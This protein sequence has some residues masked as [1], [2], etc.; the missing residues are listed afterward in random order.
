MGAT[1]MCC[2]LGN[3]GVPPF[4]YVDIEEFEGTW[5]GVEV[6]REF[7]MPNS[8]NYPSNKRGFETYV[9]D[10]THYYMAKALQSREWKDLIRN[11]AQTYFRDHLEVLLKEQIQRATKEAE[12]SVGK[13]LAGKLTIPETEEV[14]FD[15]SYKSAEAMVDVSRPLDLLSVPH[16]DDKDLFVFVYDWGT[17]EA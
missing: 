8:E 5:W 10:L 11:K 16:V 3:R 15:F 17:E 13:Y 12:R 9:R 6:G 7:G 4:H 2:D 1:L 14:E